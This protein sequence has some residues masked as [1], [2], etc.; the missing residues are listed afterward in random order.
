[1]SKHEKSAAKFGE[2]IRINT[3]QAIFRFI[4]V[5]KACGMS[6]SEIRESFEKMIKFGF[7]VESDFR[8][9][10]KNESGK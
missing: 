2:Q 8:G 5:A 3:E 1:M 10:E 9:K 6:E 7:E 4:L